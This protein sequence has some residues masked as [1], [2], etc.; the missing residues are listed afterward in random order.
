[1]LNRVRPFRCAAYIN[2]QLF[3]IGILGFNSTALC[4]ESYTISSSFKPELLQC[5]LAAHVLHCILVMLQLNL[6]TF[7]FG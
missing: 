4:R 3:P 5:K 7:H 1:M 2:K 6:Q